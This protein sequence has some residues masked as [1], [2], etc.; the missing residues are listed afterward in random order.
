MNTTQTQPTDR[1]LR[2]SAMVAFGVGAVTIALVAVVAFGGLGPRG[3]NDG[4]VVVP[5]PTSAPSAP[6]P[7]P[8]SEPSR[9]P[10]TPK[11][12]ATPKPVATPS[13][14]PTD[15]GTDAMPIRVDLRTVNDADV[16]VD[17]VDRTGLLVGAESGHPAEGVS[18][19]DLE[20]ENLDPRTLKLTWSDFPIDNALTLFVDRTDDGYRFLLIQPEPTGTTD[21]IAMDRELILRFSEP[22][23]AAEVETFLQDGLD[24]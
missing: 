23:S 4:G 6:A 18:V 21:A 16:H 15:G 10:A 24:T 8:S 1:S 17:I 3:T 7:T 11:P 12:R 19:G 14:E 5:P 9:A 2:P 13:P 20:A 22:I